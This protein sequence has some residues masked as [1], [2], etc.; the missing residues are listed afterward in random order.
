MLAKHRNR[1]ITEEQR[2]HWIRRMTEIADEV[3][4]PYAEERA[5]KK[6]ETGSAED[7]RATE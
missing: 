2:Q 1:G 4:L 3:G 6:A 7:S 5:R